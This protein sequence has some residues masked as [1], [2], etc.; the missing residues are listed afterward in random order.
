VRRLFGILLWIS[1]AWIGGG[2]CAVGG[3]KQQ[4]RDAGATDAAVPPDG[5]SSGVCGNGLVEPGE[6][7]DDGNTF[8]GDGCG[9]TCQFEDCSPTTCPTGCCDATGRCVGGTQDVACGTGGAACASCVSAGQICHEQACETLPAC[10]AGDTLECGNCGTRICDANGVYGPCQGEGACAA[11][12]SE[13]GAACGNCGTLMRTC[14]TQCDWD[15]WTCT[16]EGECAV[17]SL[18]TGGPC[19]NGGTEQRT[20]QNDCT[21][22]TWSCEG[23]G[24]CTPGSTEQGGSCGNCG[25]LERTCDAS[26]SWGNWVC[27][28]EGVCQAGQTQTGNGCGNCGTEQRTCQ[29]DCTWGTWTCTGEGV[30]APGDSQTTGACCGVDA[31]YV[32]DCT[33]QCTWGASVCEG[34]T[35]CPVTG[36]LT[37]GEHGDPCSEPDRYWRC[38]YSN[39]WGTTVSQVCDQTDFTW[40]NYHLTPRDCASCCPSWSTACCQAG[41]NCP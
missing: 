26:G 19:G 22:G 3:G 35:T 30:C 11:G 23:E 34:N 32:Q 20:C 16:N 15:A 31:S 13:L 4:S 28:A 40:H 7:C 2:A 10:T 8:P 5:T 36:H 1:L 6:Q 25:T 21:W 29:N 14:N 18:D 27:T 37:C 39:Q 12:D 41:A 9:E 38:V 33:N 24:V 17:G